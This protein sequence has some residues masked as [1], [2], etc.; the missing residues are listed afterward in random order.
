MA[1]LMAG[2][3]PEY[4]KAIGAYVPITDLTKW[5]KENPKYSPHVLACCDSEE[6]MLKRSPI[7]YVD[8]IATANLKIYHGKWDRT[9]PVSHSLTLYNEII[10][11][12]PEAHVYLDVFD[13]G[14]E[15]CLNEIELFI[16]AQYKKKNEET[17]T[18]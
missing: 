8:K 16:L 10:S 6:E 17:L 18:G 2:M 7:T 9:V 5:A 1:L 12:H 15:M 14:H 4:F 11:R 13:G 3:C